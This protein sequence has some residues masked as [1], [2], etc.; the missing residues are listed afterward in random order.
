MDGKLGCFHILATAHSAAVSIDVH[1]SLQISGGFLSFFFFFFL[2]YIH[3]SGTARSYGGSVF[4]LFSTGDTPIYIPTNSVP[5]FPFLNIL[6]NICYICSFWCL[7][8]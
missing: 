2:V 8:F 5:G 6:I 4:S 3:R 7:P 1:V